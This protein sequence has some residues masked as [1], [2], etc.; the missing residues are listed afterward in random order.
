MMETRIRWMVTLLLLGLV[1]RIGAAL[2]LGGGFY[3]ADE[4][5]YV[6]VARRLADGDGFG[7]EYHRVP[8]YPV[9]LLMLSLGLP[10]GLMFLRVVQAVVAALG[11][12]LVFWLAD[13]MFGRRVAIVAGL[14]YA[15]DPLLVISSGLLYPEAVAALLV[16]AVV[17]ATLDA[18]DRDA[19]PRSALAGALL[20]ILALLRPVALV[21][22][23][24]VAGWTTLTVRARPARRMS[25]LGALV[26]AF[27]LV[28]TP[29]TV[30][31]FLVHGS[32]VP[33]ATAGT[34]AAPVSGDEITRE[35][36]LRSMARWAWTDPG[37]LVWHVTQ[38]FV[39]FW[40]LAPTRLAT[41]DPVKRKELNRLD[42]R[43]PVQPLFP[44]SLR[45]QVSAASFGLEL[46]LA[47]LG[48]AAVARTRW[49]QAA[50]P[51]ILIL[52]YALGYALFVAKLRYR[53]PVLPLLFLFTG[54]GAVAVYSSTRRAG[55]RSRHGRTSD[56]EPLPH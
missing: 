47:L 14:V 39:L 48:L 53:I 41:D 24:V 1:A 32:L 27:F 42:P 35:G 6:D 34:E 49:R 23:P 7:I 10:T 26:L 21:L 43:L 2:T 30:R 55:D 50:L 20:G 13:R 38:Q 46:A 25:H 33:V 56:D 54:A 28:L 36:L 17:L 3:F 16:P 29:W 51:L 31:N 15:L 4:A 52:A 37:A 12:L 22:L 9:F 45:D 44:R 11:T 40:E 5:S 18:S 19:L 8:A